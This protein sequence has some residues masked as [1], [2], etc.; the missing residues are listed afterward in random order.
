MRP[1]S[2]VSAVFLG[3]SASRRAQGWAGDIVALL[4]RR[5][6]LG[7]PGSSLVMFG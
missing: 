1:R 2:Q 4:V 6:H 5:A 7:H 3:Q